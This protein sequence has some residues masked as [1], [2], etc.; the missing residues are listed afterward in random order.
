MIEKDYIME[1]IELLKADEEEQR[2]KAEIQR[3]IAEVYAKYGRNDKARS[4]RGMARG[5]E[6][7]ADSIQDEIEKLEIELEIEKLGIELEE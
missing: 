3:A 1:Q 4:R 7:E 2:M 6:A 5:H